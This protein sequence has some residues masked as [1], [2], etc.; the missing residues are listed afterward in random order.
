[1]RK[2]YAV[3]ILLCLVFFIGGWLSIKFAWMTREQY[4]AWAGIVGGLASVAGL[5]AL[6]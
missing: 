4:F 1:M 6:T 2:V 3:I 5:L